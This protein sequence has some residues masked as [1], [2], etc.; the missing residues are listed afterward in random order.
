MY[1]T[2]VTSEK[3]KQIVKLHT[4]KA[5]I[6]KELSAISVNRRRELILLLLLLSALQVRKTENLDFIANYKIFFRTP[7]LALPFSRNNT[8]KWMVNMLYGFLFAASRMLQRDWTNASQLYNVNV[9]LATLC[10]PLLFNAQS[11]MVCHYQFY[12]CYLAG[13]KNIM[14]WDGEKV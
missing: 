11:L 9:K 4:N 10:L 2:L 6:L 5:Y 8:D 3:Q 14:E 13:K 1:A 7:V 12:A